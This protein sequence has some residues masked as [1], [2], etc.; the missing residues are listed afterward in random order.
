MNKEIKRRN[1]KLFTRKFIR[2]CTSLVAILIVFTM[3]YM[4]IMPAIAID[5]DTAYAEP[6]MEMEQ[7]L[8]LACG[9]NA[10]THTDECY[11]EKDI[12]DEQG[13]PTG[14]TEKVLVCGKA[15]YVIHTHDASCFDEYGNLICPL[16]ENPGHVHS[17]E[18]GCYQKQRELACTIPEHVHTDTCYAEVTIGTDRELT[19]GYEEGQ[20]ISPAVYTDAVY[21]EPVYNEAGELVQDAQMIQE[22]QLVQEEVTHHHTDACYTE[23]PVTERQLICGMEE[24]THNDSCY[25]EKEVL[26]CTRPELHTHT[27]QCYE[28][29]PNGESPLD[30]GWAWYEEEN[31]QMVLNGDPAH[32]ICGKTELLEHV[33]TD[34]CFAPAAQENV[35]PDTLETD[36]DETDATE[37]VKEAADDTAEPGEKTAEDKAEKEDKEAADSSSTAETA[38]QTFHE[39]TANV[40]VTVTAEEGTF[41]EGTTMSVRDVEDKDILNSVCNASSGDENSIVK[42]QAADITFY[43]KDGNP[44]EPVKPVKVVMVPVTKNEEISAQ[45]AVEVVHVDNDGEATVVKQA[46]PVGNEAAGNAVNEVAFEAD[47]FSV[48]A[49]VYKVC[50]EYEVDGKTYASASM[51]GA[52]YISL[53]DVIRGLGIVSE[54]EVDTFVS[55]ISSVVS[56]NEEVAVVENLDGLKVRVLK[57]G[58]AQI[59]ITM[60]DGAQFRV[61]VVA[62]GKTMAGNEIA[63]VS[64]VGD[65]YL[66]VDTKVDAKVLNEEQSA[67]AIAAVQAAEETA[68]VQSEEE[69]TFTTVEQTFEENFTAD[70]QTKGTAAE[71]NSFEINSYQVFDISLENVD[72]D[73][74]EGFQVEVKLPENIAARDLHLYHV[75]GGNIEEIELH[76]INRPAAHSGVEI[77][78]GFTFVTEDFS[79]FV[80]KYTVDFTYECKTWSF[81][82]QG[83]Y[84]IKE[85]LE[86]LEIFGEA[87]DVTLERIVDAGGLPNAL[88]L[89]EKED[90]WY[91]T[92]EVAFQD[93][94]ELKASVDEKVYVITVT[95]AV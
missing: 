37:D 19:C 93:T 18:E 36:T 71:N 90:G 21:S 30:M 70:L 53:A 46:E 2:R 11:I 81:P 23:V 79:D 15:D 3:T 38:E 51:P 63:K 65:L 28:A 82:G 50:F 48:Y 54:E 25:I 5:Q 86:Q 35:I 9:Y 26:T 41:P 22:P 33:H 34:S 84:S 17:R 47:A 88:Y 27:E 49:L 67:N 12:L 62:D 31:G 29:G 52:E 6:G 4:L 44:V 43:D 61:D 13:N 75:H 78:S 8:T 74:Y 64:T 72:I 76:T 40:D 24:H 16:P 39:S 10:H 69:N 42:V 32:R 87:T 56:T 68:A 7:V 66:P 55:K 60:L 95:D 1:R 85:I 94:F 91:L 80:L 58:D 83:S 92:S 77:V 89:E 45:A 20:V 59:V 14:A 57:D 73:Q